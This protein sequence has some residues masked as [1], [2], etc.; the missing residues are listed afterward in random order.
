VEWPAGRAERNARVVDAIE[1]NWSLLPHAINGVFGGYSRITCISFLLKVTDGKESYSS[2]EELRNDERQHVFA[3]DV[4]K[5]LKA[6]NMIRYFSYA[7]YSV[8]K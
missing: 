7:I 5:D 3:S 2:S 1:K 6:R 8:G 4:P